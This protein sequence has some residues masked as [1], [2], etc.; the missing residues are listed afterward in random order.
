MLR[1]E[2]IH[3]FVCPECDI[4]DSTNNFVGNRSGCGAVSRL[5][6]AEEM[7]CELCTTRIFE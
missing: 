5:I 1:L 2:E 3:F 4:L 6:N 7:F